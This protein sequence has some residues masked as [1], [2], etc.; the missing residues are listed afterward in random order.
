MGGHDRS[1]AAAHHR[2]VPG[3]YRW[4]PGRLCRFCLD[5]RA[6]LADRR[7]CRAAAM[8]LLFQVGRASRRTSLIGAFVTT[9]VYVAVIGFPPPALRSAAM[10]GVAMVARIAQRPTSP[11]AAW[12]VGGFVPLLQPR[13]AIDVGYQLSVLGMCALVAAGVL[14]KRY[15][16]RRLDGWQGKIA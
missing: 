16:A 2:V 10:L 15:L 12:A 1:S 4:S 6:L 9:A 14:W 7:R 13:N 5:C 3:R 8:E 11:W